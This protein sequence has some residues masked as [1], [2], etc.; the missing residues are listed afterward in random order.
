MAGNVVENVKSLYGD[1][2][3]LHWYQNENII[4][5]R[6]VDYKSNHMFI[7]IDDENI[8]CDKITILNT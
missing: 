5:S 1:C 8:P 6:Y 3:V 7:S 2:E 4:K